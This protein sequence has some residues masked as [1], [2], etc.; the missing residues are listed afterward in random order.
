MIDVS[1]RRPIESAD[2]LRLQSVEQVVLHPTDGSVVYSITWPDEASDANRSQLHLNR[3]PGSN[4][5]LTYGHHDRSP[6]FSPDGTRLAFVRTASPATPDEPAALMLLD[7]DRGRLHQAATFI[8]GIDEIHWVDDGRLAVLAPRRPADQVDVDA[9]ELA[10]RPR[11]IT[12]ADYRFNGRGWMHDRPRQVA[13]VTL[14]HPPGRPVEGTT[15]WLEELV[16]EPG[17]PLDTVDHRG[18]TVAP[19]GSRLAVIATTAPDSDLTHANEVWVHSLDGTTPSRRVTGAEGT[20][21]GLTWHPEGPIVAV[22]SSEC[23]HYGFARPHRLD[24]EA[25]AEGATVLGP[26]DLNAAPVIGARTPPVA[27]DGGVLIVQ[28]RRGA[29]VI[30]RYD[31][32]SGALTPVVHHEAA[33]VGFDTAP[34]GSRLVA[35]ITTVDRPAELWDASGPDPVRLAALNDDV[36]AQLDLARTEAVEVEHP[37]GHTIHAFVT[38]PPASAPPPSSGSTRPGL[39]Y[40]HGGP[41]AQYGFSFFDE[42][43][44]AA[45]LGFVVIGANPRGSDGYGEEW[46]PGP[47]RGPRHRR[48]G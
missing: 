24:P 27:V 48:L 31:L 28:A 42:F 15:T 38:I 22:G 33:V 18:L 44:M 11:V 23:D 36:L 10:R 12:R 2:L 14:D 30:D 34:D 40:V 25:G 32:A 8:D 43:Q 17:Y 39:V 19:D 4:R 35:A 45:A 9:E 20:W 7:W 1:A 5:Q 13:V 41:M 16:A 6:R 21:S 47:D 37:D 26:H 3:G 46:G 29:M